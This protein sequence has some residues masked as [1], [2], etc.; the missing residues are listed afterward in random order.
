MAQHVPLDDSIS[1]TDLAKACSVNKNLLT[2]LL[3]HAMVFY[4]FR[5]PKVCFVAHTIDT[6]ILATHTDFSDAV[7]CLFEDI[8]AGAQNIVKAIE[9]RPGLD[10]RHHSACGYAYN[11]DKPWFAYL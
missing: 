4:L 7:G 1:F 2:R 6:R 9:K 11:T 8:D 5:E 10:E 3:R